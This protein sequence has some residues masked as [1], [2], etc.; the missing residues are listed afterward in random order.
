MCSRLMRCSRTG[1]AP[2]STGAICPELKAQHRYAMLLR[3]DEW[4]ACLK[5]LSIWQAKHEIMHVRCIPACSHREGNYDAG[6][7]IV[8]RS[9]CAGC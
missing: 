4:P 8:R 9:C 3:E 2:R 5:A 7:G 1:E 6:G